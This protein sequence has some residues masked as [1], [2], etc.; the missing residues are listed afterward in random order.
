MSDKLSILVVG[1]NRGIGFELT[2]GLLEHGH[3]VYA[4]YRISSKDDVSVKELGKTGA[5]LIEIDT[6][7]EES[8][9]NAAKVF[10]TQKV[11]ERKLDVLVHVAGV[12]ELWDEKPFTE[13]TAEDMMWHFKVNTVG[14]FLTS[15]HFF[16]ALS[17]SKQGKIINISSDFGSISD[18]TGG[19][20][21]YRISKCGVNQL[22]K[23]QHVDLR[24]M[25][26][27][28]ITLAVHPGFVATKM[29]GYYGEDDMDECRN[30]LVKIVETF[31]NDNQE[32]TAL[33]SGGYVRWNGEKMEY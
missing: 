30:G 10:D 16:P 26:S 14:P 28:I 5:V 18:N 1:A 31:G 2:K 24:K 12:Y 17:K 11:H 8:I 4:S 33:K 6:S 15:K 27:N 7:N 20:A 19:N 21:C 9:A 25:N 13:L 32:T 22:I 29:T 3:T 23:T